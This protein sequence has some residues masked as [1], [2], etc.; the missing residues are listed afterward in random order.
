M[1]SVLL[2]AGLSLKLSPNLDPRL[3]PKRVL[4]SML[5]TL[6]VVLLA[7]CSQVPVLPADAPRAMRV[8][9]LRNMADHVLAHD[10]DPNG[11][12]LAVVVR[13]DGKIVY[14]G[15]AGLADRLNHVPITT[16]T[17]FE[18]ASASKPVTAATVLKLVE[19]GAI[20][21]Q[22]PITNWLSDLP[23]DWS[24]ISVRDLLT[25]Q[26]GIPDYMVGINFRELTALNGLTNS[27]LIERWRTA[28]ALKF[29]PGSRSEY[30]NSNYVLLAEIVVRASHQ[31]FGERLAQ[32]I[33]SPLD[34]Q[35][36]YVD[37]STPPADTKLALNYGDTKLTDGIQ[38]RTQGP[39]GVFSSAED[40]SRWLIALGD[41]RVL[42]A[43][44]LQQM[45]SPQSVGP[46]FQD[47]ER[48][49]YGWALPALGDM[50]DTYAHAGKKDGYQSILYVN[51]A[52][53]LSYVILS[54]GGEPLAPAVNTIRYWI[55][56][57]L[58]QGNPL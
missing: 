20:H 52:R 44:M 45:T 49:G 12:G 58:E 2:K 9:T 4:R 50:R 55:Q 54:N 56:T 14:R 13:L 30:S 16:N 15:S 23:A 48:Y 8:A 33:F 25:H 27:M 26:S 40:L 24:K 35:A 11:P 43:A 32:S 38:L 31:S 51:R 37:G 28:S 21:L 41:G 57:F 6:S 34:M 53:K 3:N 42:S 7:A 17:A 18:L 1:Q 5:G 10:V 22:D 46:T 39:T 29:T 19:T 36:S 47:G